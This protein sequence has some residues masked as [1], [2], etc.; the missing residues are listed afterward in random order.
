LAIGRHARGLNVDGAPFVGSRENSV[1]F[2]LSALLRFL[3]WDR[4]PNQPNR[5]GVCA[6]FF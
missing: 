1:N 6:E 2:R 3:V 5:G 4:A